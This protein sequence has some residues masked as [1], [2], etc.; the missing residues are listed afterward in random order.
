[1]KVLKINYSKKLPAIG[2]LILV[3]LVGV[4]TYFSMCNED[5]FRFVSAFAAVMFVNLAIELIR[6]WRR[7][8]VNDECVEVKSSGRSASEMW[9]ISTLLPTRASIL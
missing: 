3:P 7:I 6:G 2:L 1:M 8:V 4:V 5:A 9:R